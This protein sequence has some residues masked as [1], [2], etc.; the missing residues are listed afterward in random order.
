MFAGQPCGI[1]QERIPSIA[2]ELHRYLEWRAE[3]EQ[4]TYE[5]SEAFFV[6]ALRR[7]VRKFFGVEIG[8]RG[9][10]TDT[11]R[12]DLWMRWLQR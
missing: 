8:S 1:T 3:Q 12:F 6:D 2:R 10:A 11:K 7:G 4:Q 5:L 9:I